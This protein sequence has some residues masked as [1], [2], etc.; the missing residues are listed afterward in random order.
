MLAK[1]EKP[2]SF[3]ALQLMASS[4][5]A[6]Y[7]IRNSPI[8]GRGLYASQDIPKDTWILQ[9]LGEK[10]DK[11]ESERRANAL[12]EQSKHTGGARVY[13]FI[14]DDK[15]DIDGDV[16]YNDARL[17]NHSC[18]PNVEA[19]IWKGKEIWF[20]ALRDIKKGEELFFNYGFDLDSWEDHPCCCGSERCVGYIAAEEYWPALKRK[21]SAKKAWE[22]RRAAAAKSGKNGKNASSALKNRKKSAKSQRE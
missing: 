19:Q 6:L 9:Y 15:W 8:H 22:K 10:I 2:P 13:M 16:E 14:L 5:N 3:D 1:V 7:H 12:L 4:K 21:I 17:M 20:T 18:D 11:D